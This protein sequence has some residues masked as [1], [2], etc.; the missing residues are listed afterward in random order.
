MIKLV[1]RLL[2]LPKPAISKA[3]AVEI[4]RRV[5]ADKGW[6]WREPIV[7]TEGFRR[8]HVMTSAERKG[9]NANIRIDSLT[10]RVVSAVLAPR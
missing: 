6:Q 3:D 1:R 8:Y 9:G 4:A 7:V 10:G 2:R 5:C